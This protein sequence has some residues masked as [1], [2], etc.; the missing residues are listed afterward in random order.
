MDY[1]GRVIFDFNDDK[2]N[3]TEVWKERPN[4]ITRKFKIIFFILCLN[5][6]NVKTHAVSKM[7]DP[8][9]LNK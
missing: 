7:L 6:I 1:F 9:G 4:T 5:A 8:K 2:K 3:E